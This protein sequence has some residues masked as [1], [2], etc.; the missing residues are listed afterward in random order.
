M[1][2]L[3]IR[4]II[5]I[6]SLPLLPALVAAQQKTTSA[7]K[8]LPQ[9][10]RTTTRHEVRRFGYGGTVTLIGAPSGSIIVEGWARNEVDV[11]AEIEL[12]ADTEANLSLLAVVNNVAIDDDVNHIQILSTGTHDKVFMRS[13]AKKF[14]K[15]LLGLPWKIDYR[16]R[17]PLMTD[18][19]VN[20]GHGP[21]TIGGVEGNV[22]VTATES[23]ANLKMTGGVLSVII[24]VGK[25]NLE[26]PARSWARGSAEIRLAAG[27]IVVNIPAGFSGDF[28]AEVLR[29]GKI[30]NLYDGLGPRER[31]SPTPNKMNLRAGAGGA[32]F[33]LTVGDG[34]IYIKKQTVDSKQ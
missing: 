27:D 32:S 7:P 26:I 5:L 29:A 17:V 30:E 24:A 1:K 23:L 4:S 31:Q 28:D 8:A 3:S 18:L 12:R 11:S 33:N 16:I 21:I 2:F 14:P 20:A 10:V 19:E 6:G 34:T 9:L 25:V 22:R 15:A 13:A